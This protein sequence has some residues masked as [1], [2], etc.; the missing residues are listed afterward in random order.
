MQEAVVQQELRTDAVAARRETPAPAAAR[1]AFLLLWLSEAAVELGIALVGF[2]VGVWIYTQTGS[3]QDYSLSILAAALTAMLL[4]PF[5]GALADRYDRRS[6]VLACDIAAI[7]CG[8][9]IIALLLGGRLGIVILYIYSAA[10][11]AIGAL[12]RPAVRVAI[13]RIVPKERLARVNGLTGISRA[14]VQVGAPSG[15][16][17]LMGHFGL[18]SVMALELVLIAAGAMLVFAALTRAGSHA[19]RTASAAG[20][21]TL[22]QG[23]RASFSGA[24][25]YLA[26]QP[27]MRGLLLYGAL[28]QCLMVLATTML[29]PLVLSTHGTDVLGLVMSIGIVGG[30]AGSL[31]VAVSLIQRRLML[32][33]LIGDALQAAALLVAGLSTSTLVW[34]LAAFVCLFAGSTSVACSG[35]LWMRKAPL[36]RQG[37]V[38]ALLAAS[39]M[40]VMCL[41]L[42]LGGY[43]ADAVLEPALAAGGAWSSGVGVWFGTGKGRGIGFLFFI[44]GICGLLLTAL[45][46]ASRN[47]RQLDLHVPERVDD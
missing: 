7:A 42:L 41:V 9:A 14:L 24:L 10:T 4:T 43:L 44:S 1:Q 23:A 39:N 38:F 3:A 20:S 31:L 15:A 13:S 21:T 2:A 36:A 26:E 30:M 19:R 29:T 33:V 34:C 16:G 8:C 32:W 35:A 47:L 45:A 6:V 27:L 18:Q 37:S 11:A 40:L 5:A 17:F 22:W 12:R 25:E 46:L 28:V